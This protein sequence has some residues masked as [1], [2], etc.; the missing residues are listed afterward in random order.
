MSGNFLDAE[1]TV[2]DK[3][4]IDLMS[5]GGFIQM[6]GRRVAKVFLL[7]GRCCEETERGLC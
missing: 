5:S 3:P 6:V 2:V 7:C 1:E 4:N